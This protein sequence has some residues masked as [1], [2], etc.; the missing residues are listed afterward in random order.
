[1]KRGIRGTRAGNLNPPGVEEHCIKIWTGDSAQSLPAP[2]SW[3]VAIGF[4]HRDAQIFLAVEKAWKALPR[5]AAIHL[6]ACL[7]GRHANEG[8]QRE[9]NSPASR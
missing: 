1:L 9:L 7:V 5:L 4:T 6:T 3:K 2:L 8:V